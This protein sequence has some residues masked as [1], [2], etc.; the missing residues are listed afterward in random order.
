[1]HERDVLIKHRV[2]ELIL[3]T[4]LWEVWSEE[5]KDSQMRELGI[6]WPSAMAGWLQERGYC[7]LATFQTCDTVP[8]SLTFQSRQYPCKVSLSNWDE[9][10]PSSALLLDHSLGLWP[11]NYQFFYYLDYLMRLDFF[12]MFVTFLLWVLFSSVLFICISFFKL[13]CMTHF[14]FYERLLAGI[15]KEKSFQ[16]IICSPNFNKH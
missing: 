3:H 13:I 2:S 14:K 7:W 16:L 12:L 5:L 15:Y 11:K 8:H 9:F 10:N 1:M 6:R 4:Q